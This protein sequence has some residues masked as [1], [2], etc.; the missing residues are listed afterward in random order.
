MT[1]KTAAL[2][3]AMWTDLNADGMG[4]APDGETVEEAVETLEADGWLLVR[5]RAT[6]SDIAIMTRDGETVGI[7]DSGGPWAVE[8]DLT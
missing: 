4:W 6:S 3:L 2:A 5:D 8:L 7:G 1:S